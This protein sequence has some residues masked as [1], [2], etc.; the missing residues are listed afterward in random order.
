[1][2][3]DYDASTPANSQSRRASICDA[4]VRYVRA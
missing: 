4:I 3:F 2:L 1:V